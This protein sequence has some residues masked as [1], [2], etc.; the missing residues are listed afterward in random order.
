MVRFGMLTMI[1]DEEPVR[2]ADVSRGTGRRDV[3]ERW[4]LSS[5]G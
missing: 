1:A 4:R 3:A 5:R 2:V